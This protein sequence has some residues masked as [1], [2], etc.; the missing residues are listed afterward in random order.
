DAYK[1]SV[2]KNSAAEY[3]SVTAANAVEKITEWADIKTEH[4][5]PAL[6]PET[7]PT[8]SLAVVLMNALYFK[9]A[10]Q[11]EFAKAL[12]QEEDFHTENGQ[13]TRK[14]FMTVTDYFSYY[15]DADTRLVILPMKSGVSMAF[16]LGSVEGLAEK[17]SWAVSENVKVTIPKMDLETDFSNKELVNFL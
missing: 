10:W 14:D 12:T 15:E 17:M 16:V 13:T 3:R 9:D 11:T 2:E 8:E 5:I 4:M 1:E 6:L 7:Y